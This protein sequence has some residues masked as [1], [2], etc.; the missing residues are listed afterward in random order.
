MRGYERISSTIRGALLLLA[1]CAPASAQ[2]LSKT[3]VFLSSAASGHAVAFFAPGERA[4]VAGAASGLDYAVFAAELVA[5]LAKEVIHD[6]TSEYEQSPLGSRWSRAMP[7]ERSEFGSH[8]LTVVTRL[9]SAIPSFT[10]NRASLIVA[11]PSALDYAV[12]SATAALALRQVWRVL[13]DEVEGNRGG[14]S[15][16]PKVG[17]RRVGVN[18]TFHW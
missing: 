14:I 4:A 15:L 5:Y 12:R 9:G 6:S 18:L 8:C 11:P 13:T 7:E 10:A 1:L 17:T 3:E 16:K 2:T